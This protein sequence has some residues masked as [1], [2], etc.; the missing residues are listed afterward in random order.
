[1]KNLQPL[2]IS[3]EAAVAFLQLLVNLSV[4]PVWHLEIQKGMTK[5]AS[6]LG[7]TSSPV[8]VQ[9]HVHCIIKRS[10]PVITVGP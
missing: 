8:K 1:M 10:L 3:E 4:T 5:F 6:L 2:D 9:V 7:S